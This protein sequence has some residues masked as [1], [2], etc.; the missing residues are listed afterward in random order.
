M[1]IDI[2]EFSA[3]TDLPA[4][5][6]NALEGGHILHDP[7]HLVDAVDCLLGDMVAREPGVVIPVLDLHLKVRP[8]WIALER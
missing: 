6:R 8:R 1:V 2:A 4:T 3:G 7:G 5:V